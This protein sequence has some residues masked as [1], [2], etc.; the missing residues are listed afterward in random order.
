M[1]HQPHRSIFTKDFLL[2]KAISFRSVDS[3]RFTIAR[4]CRRCDYKNIYFKFFLENKMFVDSFFFF[5]KN[6]ASFTYL[7]FGSGLSLIKHI[8]CYSYTF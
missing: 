7:Q 1:K 5:A 8:N 4:I 3:S 6:L 2:L